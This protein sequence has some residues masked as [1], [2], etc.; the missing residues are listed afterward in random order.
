MQKLIKNLLKNKS[1]LISLGITLLIGI[2]SLIEIDVQPLKLKYSDKFNHVVAYF[3]LTFM[4]LIA[5]RKQQIKKSIVISCVIY[6]VL[7]ELLQLITTYRTFDYFDII[8]NIIGSLTGL[9][10]FN[11]VEKKL[12]KMLNNL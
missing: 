8:I 11:I 4:W 9:L 7:I 5:L 1:F 10:I 3:S 2:L 6:G 12:T